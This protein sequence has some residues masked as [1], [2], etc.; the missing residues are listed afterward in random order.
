MIDN[1]SD[2]IKPQK[3]VVEENDGDQENEILIQHEKIGEQTA[4]PEGKDPS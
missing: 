1:H 3:V 2:L 4:S